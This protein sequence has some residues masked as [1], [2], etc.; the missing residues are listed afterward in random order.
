MKAADYSQ[1][2]RWLRAAVW[3]HDARDTDPNPDIWPSATAGG[4]P[5]VGR[6][7]KLAFLENLTSLWTAPQW[8]TQRCTCLM[9]GRAPLRCDFQIGK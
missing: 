5:S 6:R 1:A 2:S 4:C 3:I 8:P 7:R 9:S